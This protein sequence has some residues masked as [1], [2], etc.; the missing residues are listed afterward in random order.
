MAA[1]TYV[2]DRIEIGDALRDE[3]V[4]EMKFRKIA[5]GTT[6]CLLAREIVQPML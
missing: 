1:F 4:A 2:R 6:V 5:G 3:L